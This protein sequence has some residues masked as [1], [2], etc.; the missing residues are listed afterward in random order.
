MYLFYPRGFLSL[1][2]L[3]L[4]FV[5]TMLFA[6]AEE[7]D[8]GT[9]APS[10][11]SFT[12]STNAGNGGS[13]SPS[14]E[15]VN[16][17][18]TAMFTVT[19]N[20][21]Y[22]IENVSGCGGTLN[23]NTYTTAAITADCTVSASFVL[24]APNTY[25]VTASAGNGGSV[26]PASQVVNEN[27]T[28]VITVT[29]DPNYHIDSVSGCGGT[30]NANT[31]TTAAITANCTV[32][33]SFAI[34]THTVS[35]SIG[36]GGSVTPTS[37]IVNHGDTASFT[38]TPDPNFVISSVRGCTGQ[39][40]GNIYTTG[41]I[42]GNCSVRARFR[43]IQ[44]TVTASAGPGGS[45][46][47]N[48][49]LVN[50]GQSATLTVTPDPNF[51]IVDVTGCGGSLLG[52]TYTTAAVSADCAV[53]ASFAIDSFTVTASVTGTGGTITPA[54]STVNF[55]DSATFTLT[56]DSG[57]AINSVTG[58][59]GGLAG[60]SYTTAPV[61]A[62]CSITA[63]FISVNTTQFTVTATA[64]GNGTVTPSLS[65]VNQGAILSIDLT[66]DPNNRVNSVSGCKGSLNGNTYTTQA[67]NADCAL[68][69]NFVADS[70]AA[71]QTVNT[72]VGAGGSADPYSMRLTE[73]SKASFSIT[74]DAGFNIGSVT[75]NGGC[76]GSLSGT[77]YTTQDI[78]NDCTVTM[79]FSATAAALVLASAQSVFT[80]NSNPA[81]T[82]LDANG[83]A[84]PD[85]TAL[86]SAKEWDC[87]LDGQTKLY[88]ESKY[89][90]GGGLRDV[91]NLYRWTD[92]ASYADQLN[93]ASVCGFN[94][95]RIPTWQELLT[96]LSQNTPI[97]IDPGF[98]ANSALLDPA[99]GVP[100]GSVNYWSGTATQ[101]DANY[102]WSV[103]FAEAMSQPVSI[104]TP[105]YVRL[106]RGGN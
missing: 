54:T 45:I 10:V 80:T 94:D 38:V 90:L 17:N 29:A 92:I 69:V 106:V 18:E 93:A 58:C 8:L 72:V 77:T 12:V 95:W 15:V 84:L 87:V 89:P 99:F 21:N 68:S 104:N 35:V 6:C 53:S 100:A 9:Q 4:F 33:A 62:D 98:F 73:G 32:T 56:P 60:S 34:D 74:P 71:L 78:S 16:E 85:Q 39:L 88:W 40:N 101:S 79:S 70:G 105:L 27:D 3:A 82:K 81:Y 52:S 22:A 61:N 64:T 7:T 28:A 48:S 14:S 36:L 13:I 76:A 20:A 26:S 42:L 91:N 97:Y 2:C 1:K 44:Y 63:S 75:G 51:H 25:V 46:S 96:L 102:I 43:P 103:D 41:A 57:F 59:A 24:I 5:L 50:I 86:F 49:Q 67:I 83:Q 31:F 47:P 23:G 65:L 37:A 19:A 11:N 55:G 66:P 30:L